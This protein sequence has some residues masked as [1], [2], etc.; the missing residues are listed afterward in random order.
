MPFSAYR[1]AL[2]QH[3]HLH[4]AHFNLTRRPRKSVATRQVIFAPESS[5]AGIPLARASQLSYGI[6]PLAERHALCLL[7]AGATSLGPELHA[8][9]EQRE[10]AARTADDDLQRRGSFIADG[11]IS[12]EELSHPRDAVTTTRAC[13]GDSGPYFVRLTI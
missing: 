11:T 2:A 6:T 8:Q 13:V 5:V 10:Q 3:P 7:P 12:A 1:E 9:L 4:D